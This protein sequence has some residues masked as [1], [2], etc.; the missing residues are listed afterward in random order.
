MQSIF[1][2][3]KAVKKSLFYILSMLLGALSYQANGQVCPGADGGTLV[4][5]DT[6][7]CTNQETLLT[8]SG[9]QGTLTWIS[10]LH[11][12]T[13][14]SPIAG[15]FDT[16]IVVY[17]AA[18]RDYAALL[19]NGIDCS[20]TSNIV[21]IWVSS[22]AENPGPGIG[23]DICGRATSLSAVP[24]GRPVHYWSLASGPGT[25]TFYPNANIAALDSVVASNYGSY[26]IA[27]NI[28][29]GTC[30]KDSVIEVV[31]YEQVTA[32]AGTDSN[33]CGRNFQ[34][35]ASYSISGA[36]GQWFKV[37]G[38]L[39]TFTNSTLPTTNVTANPG[40][41]VLRWREFN[42]S[43]QDETTISINVA[44]Q[45]VALAGAGGSAC[46]LDF[47]LSAVSSPYFGS[48]SFVSGPDNNIS[49]SNANLYNA[50]AIAS[51]YGGNYIF[52]W[53]LTNSYCSSSDTVSVNYYQQP[54]SLANN[55]ANACGDSSTI[56]AT[57]SVG[58]GLWSFYTGPSVPIIENPG[59]PVSPVSSNNQ[60]GTFSF[61]WRENNNGCT[62]SDTISFTFYEQPISNAGTPDSVCN[63]SSSVS[64]LPSTG[65]GLWSQLSGPGQ[66]NFTSP[67]SPGTNL[68][69]SDF[70]VYTLQW[71]EVNAICSDS[72]Q[73]NLSFFRQPN[74]N[75]GLGGDT[76]GLKF[77]LQ[78]IQS[79]A[80]SGGYW[81]VETGPG[82]A[83]FTP[84]DN[85]NSLANA[86][87]PGDYQFQWTE[88]NAL[89][90]D[91]S[92]VEVTFIEKPVADAG[93]GGN[94]C[95]F[96]FQLQAMP[97]ADNAFWFVASGQTEAEFVPTERQANA[98]FVVADTG[99]YQLTW[100]VDNGACFTDSNITVHFY[101]M[102]VLEIMPAD[103]VCGNNTQLTSS[104]SVGTGT[105]SLENGPGQA[106]FTDLNA[107][108]TTVQVNSFGSY[109][110]QR[111]VLNG[112]CA[113]SETVAIRFL[114][115]P[116][117]NAGTYNANQ[118]CGFRFQLNA[119]PSSGTGSWSQTAGPGAT[120]FIPE[121][122][123]PD[124]EFIA[125]EAGNYLLVWTERNEICQDTAQLNIELIRTPVAEAGP[126]QELDNEFETILNASP[127]QPNEQG[128]WTST[129]ANVSFSS[130]D[131]PNSEVSGLV[132][133]QNFL[134]WSVDN[135]YCAD[136][137][138][139]L[140]M[141]Y[142][143]FIPDVITP[144]D[145][146]ENDYFVIRGVDEVSVVD[147]VIFNRWG[148]EVYASG[149]YD[150]NW[151]GVNKSG[152]ELTNDTY[153]YVATI[154]RSR[155]LK[156]FVVIKR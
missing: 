81:L 30:T 2:I 26:E 155:V 106:I 123:A 122:N 121:N 40:P 66:V 114:E 144:N 15:Q 119:V 10:R 69:A 44:D 11:G 51:V 75:A 64:A 149:N 97:S 129:G 109:V 151:N 139:M 102:P 47:Q 80:G 4:A 137:D 55:P 133:G 140:V 43:C 35:S 41:Y 52:R 99:I 93:E 3:F 34:L 142:D 68:N 24:T 87:I 21:T 49:F 54:V 74:A 37:S 46:D 100:R 25:A 76:C 131:L 120:Q 107:E 65:S 141:V 134:S 84:A 71:K 116:A 20:D 6:L 108:S 60:F 124:A 48:W 95:G 101:E 62:D 136:A 67:G 50:S 127:L 156:G 45:P 53:T 36:T 115:A 113:D 152:A 57:P 96:S 125:V 90:K 31:F 104:Q 77:N 154:D 147:L 146:G 42:G 118:V 128:T 32:N 19:Y 8:L 33:Y 105:W 14:W 59:S 79:I 150:N 13:A 1:R 145:D 7:Q 110:F 28:G 153:F 5:D 56:S 72:A 88:T 92:L 91:S 86:T 117:A 78:A 29:D 63:L 132:L 94:V 82:T 89:C 70:G 17:P 148:M 112:A 98:S 61:I 138:T 12:T 85:A 38:G 130:S 126:D 18:N 22:F 135:G 16:I 103:S 9:S 39:L 23:G 83:V 58:S 143:I 73:V 111:N 27:W